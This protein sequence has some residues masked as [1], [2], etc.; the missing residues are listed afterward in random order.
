MNESSGNRLSSDAFVAGPDG[1]AYLV[2]RGTRVSG[3]PGGLPPSRGV[4]GSGTP[5]VPGDRSPGKWLQE[6]LDQFPQMPVF[7]C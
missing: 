4:T 2:P 6:S 7:A 5:A 3:M 1:Y